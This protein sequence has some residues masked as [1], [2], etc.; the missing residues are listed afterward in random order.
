IIN[1]IELIR[2]VNGKESYGLTTPLITTSSGAKMGKTEK[3]AVWLDEKQTSPYE[4]WQFWRNVNDADVFKYLR[5]F[6]ELPLDEEI[7]MILKL[8]LQ[9]KQLKFF[10]VRKLLPM[11]RLLL[12]RLLKT[13]P[14]AMIFLKLKLRNLI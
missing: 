14:L 2:R 10:M 5:L 7:L 13:N 6:T 1:G 9:M 4:Y 8:F 12:K 11:L 3:G